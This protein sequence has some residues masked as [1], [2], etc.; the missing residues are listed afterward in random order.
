MAAVMLNY[1]GKYCEAGDACQLSVMSVIMNSNA[2]LN[3]YFR[4]SIYKFEFDLEAF[5][6]RFVAADSGV[7]LTSGAVNVIVR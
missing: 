2:D 6:I 5:A 3:Y 4:T 1:A 7:D